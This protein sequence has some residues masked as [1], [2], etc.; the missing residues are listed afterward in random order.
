MLLAANLAAV[1]FGR[2]VQLECLRTDHLD[3]W[4]I[5]EVIY[6]NDPDLHFARG[7]VIEAAGRSEEARQGPFVGFTVH[8]NPAIHLKILVHN[9]PFDTV[10]MPLNCFDGTYSSFVQQVLPE[11]ERR[12]IATLGMESLG[13][14]ASRSCTAS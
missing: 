14:T 2:F 9:Y 11:L 6:E 3:L 7:G 10:Q 13:A 1:F 4:L 8:K 5:H 12:G